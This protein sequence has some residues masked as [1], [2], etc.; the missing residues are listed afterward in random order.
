MGWRSVSFINFR[1]H[2]NPK[3]WVV[4]RHMRLPS[5]SP[6]RHLSS[7]SLS[8]LPSSA[9]RDAKLGAQ[10]ESLLVHDLV[11]L[12]NPRT[13][14]RDRVQPLPSMP[15]ERSFKSHVLVIRFPCASGVMMTWGK[16]CPTVCAGLTPRA[17]WT[18]SGGRKKGPIGY[19]AED[20]R[21]PTHKD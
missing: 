12:P 4:S 3:R 6:S 19:S 16:H 2:G 15:R 18:S 5:D 8:I 7:F 9:L 20:R 10:C 14:P 21:L 11:L 1:F 13:L 17:P